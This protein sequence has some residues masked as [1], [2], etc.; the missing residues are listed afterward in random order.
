[1][2]IS[3]FKFIIILSIYF[4]AMNFVFFNK[5]YLALENKFIILPLLVTFFAILAMLFSLILFKFSS[6]FFTIL[7]LL[8]SSSCGYFM[9]YYSAVIDSEMI[10][11]TLQTDIKE[12]S[13]LLNYKFFIWLII[14]A[15]LP[16]FVIFKTQILYF[17][18]LKEIKNRIILILCSVLLISV[19][20]YSF[21]KTL[22]P[23][24]RQNKEAR[25]YTLP[26]YPIYS[27]VKFTMQELEPRQNFLDF[28]T[29]NLND[30]S[31]K[32]LV[33]VVGETQRS[34]NYSLNGYKINDTNFF[35][36][37]EKNLVSFRNFYSCGTSTAISLPCMF[38]DLSRND[39][40]VKKANNR[41]NLIDILKKAGVEV[42]W[43]DNN[44]GGC[45]GVCDR[46][47]EEHKVFF[48]ANKFDREI[49]N[50][51][52]NV[53]IKGPT[54]VIVHIQ[55]SH[56]PTYFEDYEKEFEK[57]V[58]IC[59]TSALENCTKNTIINTYDNSILYQDFLQEDMISYL[60][61]ID[62][63]IKTAMFFISDH[64]ESLGENGLYLHSMPYAIAPD[65]QKKVPALFWFSDEEL[66]QKFIKNKDN[67]FSHNNIF[68]T[69]LGFFDI[70][71]SIYN[72]ILDLLKI[73]N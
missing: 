54:A 20:Y 43:F 26:F 2:K 32:L 66:S 71:I 44:S 6:K 16:I 10:R 38:S 37:N 49:Y 62:K 41:E 8:I 17:S 52:K 69:I 24:F 7:F 70:N 53:E 23:F 28:G 64:G 61:N 57:F 47:D 1:M 36:K 34:A 59:N 58:P 21:S 60:K 51:A 72:S 29:V 4:T 25:F 39:F 68:H 14:L 55:G 73:I 27:G 3:S 15:I 67:E 31:K 56:G 30:K 19:N 12:V 35:T 63:N 46:L 5:I 9:F 48:N 45:K 11:N 42:F 22:V 50:L 65:F 13:N 18:L 33:F 40:S